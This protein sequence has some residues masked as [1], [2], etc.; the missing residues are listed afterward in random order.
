VRAARIIS[1]ITTLAVI[2]AGI[3]AYVM[4]RTEK[5]TYEVT[6]DVAQ[7]PNLFAGGRVA[8]RGVEVGTITDVEPGREA[9]RVTL[10]IDSTVK[11]PADA[12]LSIIPITVIS[13]RYVQLDPPYE[14]GPTLEDGDHIPLT[15]TAIPAE[16]ED[17][18]TQLRGLLH[19]LE[20]E[21]DEPGALAEL[22]TSL[23]DATRGHSDELATAIEGSADVL[24]NLAASR[25]DIEG[26][27]GNLDRV[28]A[29]LADRSSEI[30]LVNERFA[31]VT[32]ALLAD[33]EHLEGTIENL[34]LL[35]DEA[36]SLLDESGDNLG[37]SFGRLG[38][39]LERILAHEESLAKGIA[40]TNVVAQALGGTDASGRGQF[41][42]T[43]RQ[44]APGTPQAAYNYRID[45]RDTIACERI[46][47]LVESFKVLQP[48][49]TPEQL[50][51]TLL[52]FFPTTYLDD[53]TF[54]IDLLLPVCAELPTQPALDQRAEA[55]IK[56]IADRVGEKRFAEM[57]A[58]WLIEGYDGSGT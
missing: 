49:A 51:D 17:V 56:R 9:V 25:D 53:L 16:L 44:A 15:R 35:S 47:A 5:E 2:A 31:L 48:Q 43:G 14:S 41:A 26:L 27:I 30:G 6:A 32:E 36:A 11:V 8:V 52:G 57:L 46:G 22:I 58:R 55:T 33:Q 34:A 38:H 40:W 3:G 39:V 1:A 4:T 18:L 37:R 29:A 12:V 19:A 21:G 45:S 50:R 7:A 42:Y 24:S 20:P 13:D 23:D 54:I 10:E 28:F